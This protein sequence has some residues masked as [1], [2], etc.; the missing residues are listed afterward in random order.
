MAPPLPLVVFLIDPK[1]P[2]AVEEDATPAFR[3]AFLDF[4]GGNHFPNTSLLDG[5]RWAARLHG[6]GECL[7]WLDKQAA[8]G[9]FSYLAV[10]DHDVYLSISSINR[11]L[12]LGQLHQLDL[13]QPSLSHDS[14]ISHP[15]LANRPG[16]VLRETTLVES[17]APF[18]S[19]S[20]YARVKYSFGES[21]SGYGLDFVWA[22]EI[23]A[24][25]GKVAIVDAVIAKHLNPVT[26]H[27]R[28]LPSGETSMQELHRVFLNHNLTGYQVR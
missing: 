25:G 18:F 4:T 12:F 15:H 26:S 20:A 6:K 22:H 23:R 1:T 21:V 7:V 24:G 13:F 17:M 14:F 10:I 28:R 19:A 16:Y 9:E 5:H 8:L 27:S 3:V 2:F 11:L